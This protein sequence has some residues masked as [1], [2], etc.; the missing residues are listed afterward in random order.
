M[1]AVKAQADRDISKYWTY[2]MNFRF[3]PK[4]ESPISGHWY[5]GF[6]DNSDQAGVLG[7]HD[8]GPNGE[9]LI[10]IFTRDSKRSGESTVCHTKSE[11]L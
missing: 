3:V 10:K 7:W 1:A 6:F 2:S 4:N 11:F 9:P 8:V 5:C